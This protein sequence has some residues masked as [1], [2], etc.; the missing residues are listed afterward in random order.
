MK[1]YIAGKITGDNEYKAKFAAAAKN[2]QAAGHVVLNPATL[3]AGLTD[4]DYMRIG[5]A[6]LDTADQVTF[7]PD[8]QESAGAMVEMDCTWS[9]K[10]VSAGEQGTNEPAG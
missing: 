8:Y 9:R 6:M 2:L 5:M 3:P 1:I 7:L 10:E 4:A